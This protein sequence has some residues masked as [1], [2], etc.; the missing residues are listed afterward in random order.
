MAVVS[1][2]QPEATLVTWSRVHAVGCALSLLF[3]ARQ[4][5]IWP[6]GVWAAL[7][8]G[9]LMWLGRAIWTP[10]GRF[11]LANGVTAL[12]LALVLVLTLPRG[13][14]AQRSLRL[15][16]CVLV[17][18][19]AD[20]W[21]AR[22]RGDA[23]RFGAHFDMEADAL[24]VLVVTSTLWLGRGFGPWVLLAGLLRYLYVVAVWVRPG[25]AS[26]APRSRGGRYAFA[27]LM[28]GL[29][30][31][32]ALPSAWGA[33]SVLIGTAIVSFSFARSWGA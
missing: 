26:E 1:Q 5:R 32:L 31:G 17:L 28:L 4:T 27:L 14:E 30:G 23:S 19:L 15:V 25:T 22:K 9:L 16:I 6:L 8:F 12:R 7:S 21:L 29:C 10:S 2:Q 11:G 18:D 3:C 33:I 20:G 13:F 24:L